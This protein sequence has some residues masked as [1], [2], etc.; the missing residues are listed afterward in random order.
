MNNDLFALVKHQVYQVW[1]GIDRIVNREIDA[2]TVPMIEAVLR[3]DD[4]AGYIWAKTEVIEI[5]GEP[6]EC[7]VRLTVCMKKF[8]TETAR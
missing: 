5:D 4:A 7:A 8:K 6:V 1:R 3:G 2:K